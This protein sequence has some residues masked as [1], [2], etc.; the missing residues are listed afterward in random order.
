MELGPFGLSEV[1]FIAILT[2]VIFGPK[3]LPELARSLGRMLATLRRATEEL[4]RSFQA[5]VD[6]ADDV[7][8][9]REVG[10][11]LRDVRETLRDAGQSLGTEG[12]RLLLGEESEQAELRGSLQEAAE[13]GRKALQP[14]SS[15]P[16]SPEAP[17]KPGKD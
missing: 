3:G 10:K 6:A 7:T 8:G 5:E 13:L 11:E 4:K 2:L 16:D 9:L 12:R 1:V 14:E 17:S 15:S